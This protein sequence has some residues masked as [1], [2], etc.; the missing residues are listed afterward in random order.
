MATLKAVITELLALYAKEPESA[1]R[2]ATLGD[3]A[4]LK[5]SLKG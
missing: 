2:I 1:E 5:S 3:L 4:A